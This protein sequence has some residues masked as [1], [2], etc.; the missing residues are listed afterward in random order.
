MNDAPANT[1]ATGSSAIPWLWAITL[2][3]VVGGSAVGGYAWLQHQKKST[4]AGVAPDTA[5]A[6]E[7]TT[8]PLNEDYY[9]YVKLIEFR[10]TRPEGKKWDRMSGTA[11]DP[12][13]RMT[14]Q[15]AQ[16]FESPT[17]S[18]AFVAGWDLLSVDLKDV[19]F[20][21]EGEVDVESIVNA[22]VIHIKADTQVTIDVLEDDTLDNLEA[23]TVT[24]ALA[25]FRVGE[26]T[27]TFTEEEQ[28]M[29]SRM[30]V[31]IVD[32]NISLSEL[33]EVVSDR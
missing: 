25:E 5:V 28:P 6:P 3:L 24:L 33:V 1:A 23:G 29:L 10:P 13:Y 14:W 31:G 26:N 11:P 21:Q 32:R 19:I 18:D 20:D 17:R 4:G 22:P 12:F 27:L 7:P 30:V 16:V 15:D 9:V 2:L 8:V